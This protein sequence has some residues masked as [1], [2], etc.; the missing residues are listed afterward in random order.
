MTVRLAG[1]RCLWGSLVVAVAACGPTLDPVYEFALLGDNPYPPENVPM[2]EALIQDVNAR[3]GLQWVIHAGDIRGRRTSCSDELISSRF[4]LYQQFELPFV[5][6]PGDNDWFDCGGEAQGGYD[7][8]DRLDYLRSVFYP[9]PGSTTGQRS[10]AVQSQSA[11]AGFEEYV[12][13][14]I[15]TYGGVLYAT[16]HLLA[17]TRP[18][19]SSGVAT[20][21]MDAAI[22]WITRAFELAQENDNAAVFISTQADPWVLSG[23]PPLDPRRGLEPLYPVLVERSD[24]FPGQ[25]VLAV[26]DTHIFRVDKPL[27]R[28][29][30][31]LVENF[32]RVETFGDPYIHW[33]RVTVDVGDRQVFTFHQEVVPGN[34]ATIAAR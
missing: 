33:V 18:P 5:Y 25:V 24:A 32:T 23:R 7:D 2:F 31:S 3:A 22:A 8:Y 14:V 17:L 15:W 34:N 16:V 4:D 28:D 12:E 6:T 11:E 21:R 13:N 27:Y 30:G 29:D 20:H 1:P 26:G 9:D 19:T 10:M